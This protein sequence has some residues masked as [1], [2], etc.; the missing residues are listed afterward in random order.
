L[1]PLSALAEALHRFEPPWIELG[2]VYRRICFLRCEG[3][4]TEAQLVEQNEYAEAEARARQAADSDEEAESL[5]RTL[6]AEEGARVAEAIAFAEVLV[7]VLAKRLASMVPSPRLQSPGPAMTRERK[8]GHDEN[9]GIA[10]FI[11]DM[12]AQERTGTA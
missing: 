8:P 4:L 11:D 6:L 10:D 9:R 7:P 3:L 5:L 2:R 1:E 12:L